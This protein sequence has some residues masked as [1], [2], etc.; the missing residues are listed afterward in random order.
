M[1][2]SLYFFA[3]CAIR[4]R[5]RDNLTI[6]EAAAAFGL[7]RHTVANR[8]QHHIRPRP[9]LDIVHAGKVVIPDEDRLFLL[10]EAERLGTGPVAQRYALSQHSLRCWRSRCLDGTY[11]D[12]LRETFIAAVKRRHAEPLPWVAPQVTEAVQADEPRRFFRMAEVMEA[13]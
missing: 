7:A 1:K 3:D 8:I 11:G 10:L 2:T 6:A 4:L 9:G 12:A 5:R 13:A